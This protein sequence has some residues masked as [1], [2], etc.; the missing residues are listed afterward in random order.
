MDVLIAILTP[1]LVLSPVIVSLTDAAKGWA[2]GNAPRWASFALAV[3]IGAALS[4]L[5][6]YF[7]DLPEVWQ[8]AVAGAVL[9]LEATGI[10]KVV[11]FLKAGRT[12]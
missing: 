11:D 7:P 2:G 4:L 10:I 12:R 3:V 9:G 6:T 1:M 5:V 8:V